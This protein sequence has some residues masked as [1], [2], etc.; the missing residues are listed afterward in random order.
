MTLRPGAIGQY[1]R[2]KVEMIAKDPLVL[3]QATVNAFNPR[4]AYPMYMVRL[5]GGDA[6]ALESRTAHGKPPS[7]SRWQR[8]G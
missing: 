6:D 2:V 3:Q 4:A 8:P 7:G 5:N 1:E